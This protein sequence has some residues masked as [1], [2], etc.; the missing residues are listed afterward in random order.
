MALLTDVWGWQKNTGVQSTLW[1]SPGNG[2]GFPSGPV[3]VNFIVNLTSPQYPN[4]WSNINVSVIS[5]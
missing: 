2:P 1:R 5:I 4:I 3:M